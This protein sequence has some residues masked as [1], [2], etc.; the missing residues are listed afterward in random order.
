MKHGKHHGVSLSNVVYVYRLVIQSSQGSQK[1]RNI[2][3]HLG[4]YI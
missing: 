1:A 2:E 3:V 4:L